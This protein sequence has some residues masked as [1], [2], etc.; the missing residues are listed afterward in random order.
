MSVLLTAIREQGKMGKGQNTI[1]IMFCVLLLN[2]SRKG[3]YLV[4]IFFFICIGNKQIWHS[5]CCNPFIILHKPFPGCSSAWILQHFNSTFPV[6][7][8]ISSMSGDAWFY[9]P[10]HL[11]SPYLN[12]PYKFPPSTQRNATKPNV[13]WLTPNR[14]E[15]TTAN[16]N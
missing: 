13:W 7:T 4:Y 3:T 1:G 15:F 12:C 10:A 14:T 9:S 16:L 5:V 6:L 2:N 8:K 11:T